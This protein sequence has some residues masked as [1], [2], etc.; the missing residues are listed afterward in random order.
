[1]NVLR[2]HFVAKVILY[3]WRWKNVKKIHI[4]FPV[5]REFSNYY[6]PFS[7]N[8]VDCEVKVIVVDLIS[9]ECTVLV[10]SIT[11]GPIAKIT[12]SRMSQVLAF[13][14]RNLK[15]EFNIFSTSYCN[16]RL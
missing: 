6:N 11:N 14:G 1:M 5:L 15:H 13:S 7:L 4:S 10:Q 3:C 2:L 8:L 16:F 12:K 9:M